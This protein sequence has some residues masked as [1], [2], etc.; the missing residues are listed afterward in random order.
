[1]RIFNFLPLF[2]GF[3][4]IIIFAYLINIS[5]SA[6]DYIYKFA[7]SELK[8]VSGDVLSLKDLREEFYVVHFF[9]SSCE[10]CFEDIP[11]LQKIRERC[12][13]KVIGILAA[14]SKP[15]E[16]SVYNYLAIDQDN[17]IM[18]LLKDKTT[19]QTLVVNP[20]GMVIFHYVGSLDKREI[21]EKVLPMIE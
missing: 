11:L 5:Y 10:S 9:S 16:N 13:I 15:K 1:M 20:K 2:I 14:N 3:V 17:H 4:I 18:R 6:K 12:K 21:E 19:P 7:D 8:L